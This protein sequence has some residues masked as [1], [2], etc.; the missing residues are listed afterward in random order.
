MP[1]T[2][3]PLHNPPSLSPP[4]PLETPRNPHPGN[5]YPSFYH[6]RLVLPGFEFYVSGIK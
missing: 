6:P 3:N 1:S 4:Q 2:L 5:Q